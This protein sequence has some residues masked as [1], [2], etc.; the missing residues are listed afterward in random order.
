MTRFHQIENFGQARL[1]EAAI[2]LG[3]GEMVE[4]DGRL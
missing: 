3:S 1:I 4:D 2:S